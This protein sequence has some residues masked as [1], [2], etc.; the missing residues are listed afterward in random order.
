MKASTLLAV[1]VALFLALGTAV[2]ARA[3]GLF[4]Q[5]P[6]AAKADPVIKIL[7]ARANLYE[8][9]AITTGQVMIRELRPEE[10]KL[11]NESREKFLPASIEAA[12]L[13]VPNRNIE[14]D[15]PLLKTDLQ[16]LAFPDG[17]P[18][19]MTPGMRA[20]NVAVPKEHAAGGLI[21]K[22]DH[23]DV[24]LT[25]VVCDGND[26]SKAT[27][28]GAYIARDLRVIV[29]RN[30]LWTT[31]RPNPDNVPVSFT[32]EANPYRA[33]LLEFASSKGAISLMPAASPRRDPVIAPA[34]TAPPKPFGIP[35]SREYKDED[36]RVDRLLKGEISITNGD[37][38]RIFNLRPVVR[39]QPAPPPITIQRISGNSPV[40]SSVFSADGRYIGNVRP[41]QSAG[42]RETAEA[43]GPVVAG[44]PAMGYT[45][46][47]PGS[48]LPSSSAAKRPGDPGYCPDCDASIKRK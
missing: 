35:D 21:S 25:S 39:P 44:A 9:M 1:T 26:C 14:A 33:A 28:L 37:L 40:G 2:G 36:E 16:D 6:R 46:R 22:G 7:V 20:V 42:E 5:P 27:T 32:L 11:Y 30:S 12:A 13:R 24:W 34:S 29:K 31:L 3:L 17:V 19:R 41:G 38:E 10:E 47:T 43:S 15:T 18:L 8:G 4:T 23:V 45:F 48:A